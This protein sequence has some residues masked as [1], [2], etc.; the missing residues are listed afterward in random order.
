MLGRKRKW[1]LVNM[2][3][4]LP[5]N[6]CAFLVRIHFVVIITMAIFNKIL[7]THTLKNDNST[8]INNLGKSYTHVQRI[9]H[10]AFK[11]YSFQ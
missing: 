8:L 3:N 10:K 5:Q 9:T 7:T 1:D 11:I 6:V 2:H 4:L